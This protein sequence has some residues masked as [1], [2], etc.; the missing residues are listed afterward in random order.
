MTWSKFARDGKDL[1]A[2][3]IEHRVRAGVWKPQL[4]YVHAP[5][6]A[7][8]R[9]HFLVKYPNRATTRIAAAGPVIGGHVA[10]NQ[11]MKLII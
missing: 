2:V 1:Y 11:G 5:D 6:E 4:H 7:T 3:A 8:A 9:T 10:D